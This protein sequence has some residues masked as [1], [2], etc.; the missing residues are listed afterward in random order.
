MIEVV[1]FGG[2]GINFQYLVVRDLGEFINVLNF[3]FFIFLNVGVFFMGQVYQELEGVV[4]MGGCY[5][6]QFL[7]N[8]QNK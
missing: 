3:C 6:D 8:K 2:D 1:I 4:V 5:R 7:G